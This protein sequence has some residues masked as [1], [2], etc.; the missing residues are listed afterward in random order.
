MSSSTPYRPTLKKGDK[1]NRGNYLPIS[2]ISY[3][4][5]YVFDKTNDNTEGH[6]TGKGFVDYEKS[7]DSIKHA[8][9]NVQCL[10]QTSP[11]QVYHHHHHHY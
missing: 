3:T 4:T 6:T 10:R 11:R 5:T 2:L 9:N 8:R 7:F 1:K